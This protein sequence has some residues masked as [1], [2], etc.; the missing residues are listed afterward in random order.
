[1]DIASKVALG[2]LGTGGAVGGGFLASQHLF[3]ENQS[4][5]SYKLQQEGFS[6]MKNDNPQWATTLSKYNSV[7]GNSDEAFEVSS[8][9]LT[10]KQLKDKCESVLK[11]ESYSESER[12]KAIRWCTSPISVKD[13]IDKLGRRSLHDVDGGDTDKGIWVDLVKK[14]LDASAKNKLGI[15]INTLSTN[16]TVDDTRINSIK[17]GCRD[18]KDKTSIEKDYLSDYSKFSDWCSVS[19]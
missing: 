17:K 15:S 3:K 18:L 6:P 10:D 1:M 8:K 9:E 14:H 7:K 12:V 4:T 5:L 11:K 19:K 2:A 13:R 16:E